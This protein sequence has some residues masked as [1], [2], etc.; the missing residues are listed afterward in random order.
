MR[1]R[2]E[3]GYGRNGHFE[4]V[5]GVS[6]FLVQGPSDELVQLLHGCIGLFG[7]MAHDGGDHLALVELFLA[8]DDVFRGDATFR[9][10]NVAFV[11]SLAEYLVV[12]EEL[13]G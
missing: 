10:I 4:C 3:R 11:A 8:F 2:W 6:V 7:D 9:E 1:G 13:M 5:E 12:V